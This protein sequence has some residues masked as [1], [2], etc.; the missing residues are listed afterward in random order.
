MATS[1]N[2]RV[3]ASFE[4]RENEGLI[5]PDTCAE[6]DARNL[7]TYTLQAPGSGQER[8]ARDPLWSRKYD[9]NG[10]VVWTRQ[11]EATGPNSTAISPESITAD[12]LGNVYVAGET[13][14]SLAAPLQYRDQFQICS[15]RSPPCETV[16]KSPHVVIPLPAA[17]EQFAFGICL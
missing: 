4:L 1:Q 8:L 17:S 3:T 13:Y 12:K 5:L 7:A 11:F 16:N 10:D 6:L 15:R 9:G 2:A 14:G